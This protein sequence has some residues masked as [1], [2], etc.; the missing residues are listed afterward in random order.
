MVE[1][2]DWSEGLIKYSNWS[3]CSIKHSYRFECSTSMIHAL[4]VNLSDQVPGQYWSD[5]ARIGPVL[6]RYWPA[7][8][9]NLR[10]GASI[11]HLFWICWV[12]FRELHLDIAS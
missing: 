12:H 7:L 10:A 6:A 1:I 5:F 9:V 11:W 8:F 3:A 2:S 4:F